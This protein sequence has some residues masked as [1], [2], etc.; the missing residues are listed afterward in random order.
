MA[1]CG[2]SSLRSGVWSAHGARR[3]RVE[4]MRGWL[5]GARACWTMTAPWS[6]ARRRA[7]PKKASEGAGAPPRP[8]HPRR[9]GR[10]WRDGGA[11]RRR[12][13]HIA[14]RRSGS[15]EMLL[16]EGDP[17]EAAGRRT[18]CA[19][20]PW[21]TLAETFGVE[22]SGARRRRAEP[23]RRRL[24]GARAERSSGSKC[25]KAR[26]RFLTVSLPKP[27]HSYSA[28]RLNAN[29]FVCV[30]RRMVAWPKW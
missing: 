13:V 2:M 24:A 16:I 28:T 6:A 7:R 14:H 26:S 25:L 23:M 1:F 11:D 30:R 19:R 29:F 8:G 22:R 3:R 10:G 17:R 18:P 20:A 15:S 12:R 9:H 21:R 4:A 5:A 27:M